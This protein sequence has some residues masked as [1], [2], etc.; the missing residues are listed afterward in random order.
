MLEKSK[1]PALTRALDILNFISAHGACSVL[2]IQEALNIP[3]S[4]IYNI[5]EELCR[6]NYLIKSNDGSEVDQEI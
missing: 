4:S 1:T 2:Q 3:K 6:Q 5:L